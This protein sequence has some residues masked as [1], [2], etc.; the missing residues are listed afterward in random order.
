MSKLPLEILLV[1]LIAITVAGCSKPSTSESGGASK[2]RSNGSQ[3]NSMDNKEAEIAQRGRDR[4]M[5]SRRPDVRAEWEAKVFDVF[6]ADATPGRY[7]QR[8]LGPSGYRGT[9]RQAIVDRLTGDELKYGSGDIADRWTSMK[10][11][12]GFSGTEKSFSVDWDFDS[13]EANGSNLRIRPNRFNPGEPDDEIMRVAARLLNAQSNLWVPMKRPLVLSR[14][15]MIYLGTDGD[16]HLQ[17]DE[18]DFLDTKVASYYAA[19]GIDPDRGRSDDKL[20]ILFRLRKAVRS[21]QGQSV[22]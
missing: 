2:T 19:N 14:L 20:D 6:A 13:N 8:S 22:P 17:R 16:L 7:E 12:S 15:K 4:Q 18:R 11:R 9:P 3:S 21:T 1:G 5:L 10:V